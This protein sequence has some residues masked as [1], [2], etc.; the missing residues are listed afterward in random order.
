MTTLSIRQAHDIQARADFR[1]QP[2]GH[3]AANLEQLEL[4]TLTRRCATENERFRN[5]Q[6]S[7]PSSAY[8]LFR[9]A[10][11]ERDDGAWIALYDLYHSLVEHWVCKSTAF[12]SSGEASDA[13]AGE[14]F[15][16]FWHA[17][18]PARFEQ[19]PSTAALLHYLQ[20][21]AGC[22]VIDSARAATRLAPAELA[23][24]SDTHQRAPDEEVLERMRR[25]DLWRYIGRRLNGEAE[26]VVIFDSFVNGLKPRDIHARRPDLFTSVQEVYMVKR[27]VL[28]RLSRDQGLRALLS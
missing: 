5:G 14:A 11:V 6:P 3:G 4:D 23:P 16:R 26:R 7:D 19:F 12:E 2:S 9:R 10:L 17:I 24:L 8:E 22:V 1:R 28:E 13:L 27:N 25:E 20:L 15:A 21:C 18:P